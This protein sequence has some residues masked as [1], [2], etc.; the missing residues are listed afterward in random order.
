[1]PSI[2]EPHI[3]DRGDRYDLEIDNDGTT[4]GFT[5]YLDHQREDGH[6]ERIFPHTEVGE[7]YSGHGLASTLVRSALDATIEA[8][9][10][11][12]PVCPYVKSWIQK[13]DGYTEYAIN[14]T[15]THLQLLK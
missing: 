10:T 11:I 8:G 13:H 3:V 2:E 4:A 12:V 6:T 9:A 1:M 14:P 15:P 7:D 5:R